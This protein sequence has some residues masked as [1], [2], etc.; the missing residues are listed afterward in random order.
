[1]TTPGVLR[2]PDGRSVTVKTTIV[3]T[4]TVSTI[5]SKACSDAQYM[6]LL[7]TSAEQAVVPATLTPDEIAALQIWAR[8]SKPC[9]PA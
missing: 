5:K 6:I 8:S 2:Y 1:M 9:G 4:D 3:A 7:Q